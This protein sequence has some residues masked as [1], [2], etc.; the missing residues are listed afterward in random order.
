MRILMINKFLF[1][2]G[3]A[4]TYMLRLGEYLAN[5]GHSVEYFGME[6]GDRCVGNHLNAY[7]SEMD[8]HNNSIFQRMQYSLKTIY[9]SEARRKLRPL[10]DD[11]LPEAVHLNNFN[12]QLTPSIILEIDRWRK[13]TG[14]SCRI[15]YT[16]HDSQL[17]CP[18]HMLHNPNT[19]SNCE[20]CL[21][22]H[23]FHC[24]AGKCIHGSRA[25]SAV[26]MVEAYFW[27]RKDVYRCIDT[28]ISCSAFMKTKLD[29]NPMLKKKTV[30]LRNFVEK[31][32]H[33]TVAAKKDYVLYFG[34]L[35]LEKGIG[36]LTDVCRALPDI[37]F[38]FAGKGPLEHLV[39][40]I[41]N[42]RWAG[43]KTGMEL[44]Q[45]IREA[46]FSICP[47]ECYENCPFSVLESIMEGTPVLGSDI[48]G[49]PEL[50]EVGR[51]GELF[52]SGNKEE[53]A[54]KIRKLWEN[55]KL[56][57]EYADHCLENTFCTI[58]Q[59]A[60]KLMQI[61]EGRAEDNKLQMG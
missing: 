44:K 60:E 61:Y 8:F 26:G 22:G 23:F 7:T 4:E 42:V 54:K 24:M 59:Y 17:V 2:K 39:T 19:D 13:E 45:L 12:Y 33:G 41:P 29:V 30:V 14:H 11:F 46:R 38:V 50:I 25:K 53:L 57:E 18:N 5:A 10:L 15:I 16:A 1:P 20:K 52:E 56:T 27:N 3:G 31:E 32:D 37:L 48:G 35:S 40:G 6:H 34:R 28:I 21:G 43:F 9:S 36:L 51:T 58:E 47:S 55:R 49:I